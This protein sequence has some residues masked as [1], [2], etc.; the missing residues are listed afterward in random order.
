MKIPFTKNYRLIRFMN[1]RHGPIFR[2]LVS[3]FGW[4]GAM[5]V[6]GRS[7]LARELAGRFWRAGDFKLGL[8]RAAWYSRRG[9]INIDISKD[10]M[11]DFTEDMS[12]SELL[13]LNRFIEGRKDKT[14]AVCHYADRTYVAA[15][16]LDQS[17]GTPE[18]PDAQSQFNALANQLLE[19]PEA[20]EVAKSTENLPVPS[21]QSGP[22][23]QGDFPVEKAEETLKHFA[24][25]FPLTDMRWF[26]ISGTLL[27]LIREKGFLPHDYDIDLGVIGEETDAEWVLDRLDDNPY[28][29]VRKYD[30]QRVFRATED[31]DAVASKIPVLIKMTHRSG[32]H[33]DLFFH[34]TEKKNGTDVVW[35]G[36]SLHRWE[37]TPFNLS[38]YE[39]CGMTVLGPADAD[40]YLTENYGN[41]R[42]PV[43][44]FNCTTDTTNMAIVH[45]PMSLAIFLRKM[46]MD[47]HLNSAKV[48][49]LR[50]TLEQNGYIRRRRDRPDLYEVS[51]DL[52]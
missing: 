46:L 19:T 4:L 35:H 43:T 51:P 17:L 28:F 34:Y 14:S 49:Q 52:F 8:R 13:D 33:I 42:V 30:H 22:R 25:S 38:Q 5:L 45:H 40:T 24:E 48:A 10:V 2:L 36:S 39:F 9:W 41:W 3:G 21:Q 26:L 6:T 37:N 12:K 15:R 20:A 50:M 23:R 18:W 47:R 1:Q 16:L 27:G 29:V 7:T 11:F 44:D 32:V 31:G